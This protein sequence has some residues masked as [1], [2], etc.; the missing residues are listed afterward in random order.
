MSEMREILL[1]QTQRLL[2]DTCSPTALAALAV[3]DWS[4]AIWAAFDEAGLPYALVDPDVAGSG[5]DLEDAMAL[6][7]LCARHAAPLPVGDTILANWLWC[8]AGGEPLQ[9][10]GALA[11]DARG[12]VLSEESGGY[13]LEGAIEDVSWA[14]L[15]EILLVVS[16]P[17]GPQFV[18]VP[19]S[20]GTINPDCNLAGERRDNVRFDNVAL[21]PDRV[22]PMLSDF[23]PGVL[24][25]FGAL[26]RCA[27]M[28]GAMEAALEL[29]IEY[30][31]TRN[32]FGRPLAKF[33]A[34]QNQVAVSVSQ[35]AAAAAALDAAVEAPSLQFRLAVAAAKVCIGEAAGTV[36]AIAHQVHGAMGFSAEYSLQRHTR[37]LWSWRDEFGSEA[38]W[39]RRLGHHVLRAEC[40]L[41]AALT[42]M[43]GRTIQ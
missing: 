29:S 41:W 25:E 14:S 27:Q 4:A 36:A 30:V 3:G 15:S 22:R 18:L 32:Q 39:R 1:D 40:G 38:L 34:V 10:P 26:A 6:V 5:A 43:P 24:E 16:M 2:A 42:D 33:Q 37:S 9:A 11:A 28:V 19:G 20:F 12:I 8:R 23:G 21:A 31:N 13:R 35:V 17:D 7:R